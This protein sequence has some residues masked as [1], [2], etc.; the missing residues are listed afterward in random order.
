MSTLTR[1]ELLRRGGQVAAGVAFASQLEWLT[2]CGS[3]GKVPTEADWNDLA[4]KLQ[5]RLVRPGE[6]GY[7]RLRI[8]SNL[9]YADVK[10]AGIAQC[11]GPED[12]RQSILWARDHHVQ[13]VARAGG[14]SYSGYSVTPGLLVDVTRMN[15]V[16]VSRSDG[17]AT[18]APGALNTDIYDGLQPYGVAFSAGRCPTVA[19]SGLTLG[20]GF[21]FSSRHLGLSADALLK[22]QVATA[23]GQIL[24]CSDTENP[25]LFWAVRGGGGGNFG[26]NTSFTFRT[27]PVGYVTLYDLSWDWSD[28]AKVISALQSVVEEA[29]DEWSMRIGL[30]ASGSPGKTKQSVGALGQFFG[31]RSE[32]VSILDPVLSAAKPRK[33]L[34]AKRTFWQAKTYLYD[35]TPVGRYAV[36]SNFVARPFPA[37]GIDVLLRAVERWPGSSNSDGGGIAL[38][39]WGGAIGR[40]A[41]EATAFVHRKARFL[42]AYDTAWG[43]NDGRSVV[44]ANLGWLDAVAAHTRPHVTEQAYQNFIDRSLADWPTAYYGKNFD[45]LVQ[46]KKQVDPNDFFHFHQSIPTSTVGTA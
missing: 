37:E 38:F 35:T 20:G 32:L 14:H 5:G 7:A 18:I 16:Q 9:R 42:M 29:P 39:A 28:A 31:P 6:T 25:D 23:D 17:T 13:A 33:Q 1:R 36:K 8:P 46:I 15:T 21:G 34:I 24:E 26:I 30:G 10:P 45:R 44:E 43:P 41:P 3:S 4:H 27:F 22:T 40:V 19:V 12:V 2:G 11:A